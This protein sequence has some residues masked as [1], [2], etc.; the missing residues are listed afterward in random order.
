MIFKN[1]QDIEP[2]TPEGTEGV[3]MR[4][5]IGK[6]EDAPRFVLRHFEVEPG[7]ETPKHSHWWEHEIYFIEGEGEAYTGGEYKPIK[8]GDTVFVPPDEE[9]QFRNTGQE[10]LKFICIV[11]HTD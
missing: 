5:A 1:V 4:V 3:R 8:A 11:P 6:A 9:H 7:G 10:S 2:V